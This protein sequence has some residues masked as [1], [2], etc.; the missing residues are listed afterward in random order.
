[1]KK[2]SLILFLLVILTLEVISQTADKVVV[3][4]TR[5]VVVEP[6]QYNNEVR[7]EF[8]R[9]TT[10]EVP[11]SG[12]YSGLLTIAPWRDNSGDAHH[13]L[14]FNE[15]G[16]FYRMG[17]PSGT[18]WSNWMRL[19]TT[20][21]NGNVGIGTTSPSY[22]LIVENSSASGYIAR[23][24]DSEDRGISIYTNGTDAGIGSTYGEKFYV[25]ANDVLAN[26]MVIDT[27]GKIGIGTKDPGAFFEINK[28]TNDIWTAYIKNGGGSSKGLL[29][30]VGYGGNI[31]NDVPTIMQLEDGNGNLRMKVNSNG[32]VS[33]GINT[34]P[35]G[36]IFAVAGKAMFEE[37]KVETDWADFVFE[38]DYNLMSLTELQTF[39]ETNKHLPDIPTA[40]EVKE[41]GVSVGEMNVNCY[42]KLKS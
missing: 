36:Y 19:I 13:Q 1:M 16:I 21:I 6:T 42:K 27:D 29:M 12:A 35:S 5:D 33:I 38:S 34:V 3:L 26:G 18:T 15:G 39:I 22:P 11:G 24:Q 25:F 10:I 31:N 14:N 40:K 17:Q 30:K 37:V 4:D 32:K 28:S 2:I 8:K 9:R 41:E 23:F 7:F 20:D